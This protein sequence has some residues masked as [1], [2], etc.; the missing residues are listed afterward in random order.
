MHRTVIPPTLTKPAGDI[1]RRT[2]LTHR[3][4]QGG[5]KTCGGVHSLRAGARTHF[6]RV[7]HHATSTI[8]VVRAR[9][10][11]ESERHTRAASDQPHAGPIRTT[12]AVAARRSVRLYLVL[13]LHCLPVAPNSTRFLVAPLYSSHSCSPMVAARRWDG[14]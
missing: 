6:L 3:R 2:W 4:W 9:T 12:T 13:L 8:T 7:L 14:R 5:I 1:L 11:R 10:R